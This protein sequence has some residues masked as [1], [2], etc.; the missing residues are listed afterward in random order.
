MK[1]S[2]S[3]LGLILVGWAG[4]HVG[5]KLSPDA[6]GM[7]VGM[8]FGILAGIPAALMVMASQQPR[9]NEDLYQIRQQYQQRPPPIQLA[10]PMPLTRGE[11]IEQVLCQNGFRC[12]L[13][14]EIHLPNDKAVYDFAF[15]IGTK[16]SDVARFA[17]RVL[18]VGSESE[19]QVVRSGSMIKIYE[20]AIEDTWAHEISTGSA[21]NR[22]TTNQHIN[23][24][25]Q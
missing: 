15:Q 3:F 21:P 8:L 13:R 23:L 1:I 14:K 7:A 4:W 10:P 25:G 24:L 12:E 16:V 2:V 20:Q 11:R 9:R 17:D 6:L 5:G 22:I 19:F 18:S